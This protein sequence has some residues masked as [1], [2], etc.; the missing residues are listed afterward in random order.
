MSGGQW[1]AECRRHTGI[2]RY[3]GHY[4]N[5]CPPYR[6]LL[7]RNAEERPPEQKALSSRRVIAFWQAGNSYLCNPCHLWLSS[8]LLL[9]VL[10][11][12]ALNR[13]DRS[14]EA[15]APHTPYLCGIERSY[16]G[17]L[18]AGDRARLHQL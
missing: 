13:S 5:Q 10:C 15:G 7:K 16:P 14:E 2:V 9:C 17:R 18:L 8:L 3:G 4:V 6:S 11:A 12:Y 1:H